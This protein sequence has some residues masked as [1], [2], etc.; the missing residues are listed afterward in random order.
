M[1]ELTLEMFLIGFFYL[2]VFHFKFIIKTLDKTK[3][4]LE[5]YS[6]HQCNNSNIYSLEPIC[7]RIHVIIC[8]IPL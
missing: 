4:N 3:N 2:R 1:N 6:T 7:S 8:L 5:L